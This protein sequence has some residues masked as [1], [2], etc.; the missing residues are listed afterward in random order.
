MPHRTTYIFPR[1]FPGRKFDEPSRFLL[2]HEKKLATN[3][4]KCLGDAKDSNNISNKNTIRHRFKGDKIHGKQLDTFVKW[5]AEKKK[6]E[7]SSD[8]VNLA[9]IGLYNHDEIEEK[10]CEYCGSQV[11]DGK[12][13]VKE[14]H[15]QGFDFDGHLSSNGCNSCAHHLGNNRNFE[16]Q[17]SLE[18]PLSGESTSD[19]KNFFLGTIFDWNSLGTT[20]GIL[21]DSTKT[22]EAEKVGGG[23]SI[24]K[25]LL[26]RSKESYYLQLTLA[27][28]LTE[29]ATL[30]NK[31]GFLPELRNAEGL[32]CGSSDAET[33]SY[34]FWVLSLSQNSLSKT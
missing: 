33:V 22:E 14:D 31:L 3:N 18:R 2:D 6:K 27:K 24:D 11:H 13:I 32:V 25:E 1:Q 16:R 19:S 8:Y 26:Q 4:G 7:K 5:L 28:R 21:E 20:A 15:W 29:Q 12:S 10:E 30:A 34:R 23:Y 9:M 17:A